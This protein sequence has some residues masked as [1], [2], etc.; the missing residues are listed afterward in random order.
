MVAV[1]VVAATLGEV[2]KSYFKSKERADKGDSKLTER[3]QRYELEME[4]MRKRIRNLEVIAAG[5]PGDFQQE[6]MIDPDKFDFETEEEF[7]EKL[8]NQLARKKTKG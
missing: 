6:E 2:L 1:I 5:S 4:A 7:N 8:I 3:L